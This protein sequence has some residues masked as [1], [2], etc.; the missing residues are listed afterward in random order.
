[1]NKL[2]RLK[3]PNLILSYNPMHSFTLK[4]GRKV[5]KNANF[6][7]ATKTRG[8]WHHRYFKSYRGAQNELSQTKR[9]LTNPD[10]VAY[11]GLEAVTLI[12]PD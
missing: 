7:V 6:C 1:M 5:N 11:Y 3:R 4:S 10:M 8:R 12:K 2:G 9:F